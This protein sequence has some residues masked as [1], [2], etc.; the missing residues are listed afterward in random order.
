MI[1]NQLISITDLRQNA[2]HI[3]NEIA[4]LEKIVIVHNRP[5]AAIIDIVDY[6]NYKQFNSYQSLIESVIFFAE[7][8]ARNFFSLEPDLY[9]NH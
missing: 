6:E 7:N 3:L 1:S 4:E 9:A 8:T 5:K 2:T